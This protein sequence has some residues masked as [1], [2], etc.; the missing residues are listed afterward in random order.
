MRVYISKYKVI[1]FLSSYPSVSYEFVWELEKININKIKLVVRFVLHFFNLE[2]ISYCIKIYFNYFC[3]LSTYLLMLQTI[4]NI[5]HSFFHWHLS[6][7]FSYCIQGPGFCINQEI[8]SQ[9]TAIF[10]LVNITE[11]NVQQ[12]KRHSEEQKTLIFIITPIDNYNHHNQ[13]HWC[14]DIYVPKLSD[15]CGELSQLVEG[16]KVSPFNR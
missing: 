12:I 11:M 8:Q 7:T 9:V 3:L 1:V 5:Y 2:K 13:D 4:I 6:V 15:Q 16:N 10:L 14:Q